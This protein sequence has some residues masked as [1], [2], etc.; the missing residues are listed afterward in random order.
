MTTSVEH[1][2]DVLKRLNPELPNEDE[3]GGF[4]D[5]I[6]TAYEVFKNLVPIREGFS[7]SDKA[8]LTKY[9]NW[10][11]SSL[12]IIRTP[13][14]STVQSVL[15]AVSVGELDRTKA[16]L[17]YDKMF[18]LAL[19]G[20]ITPSSGVNGTP[21]TFLTERNETLRLRLF[22]SNDVGKDTEKMVV[23]IGGKNLTLNNMFDITKRKIGEKLWVY[24]PFKNNCQDFVIQFL[25][26]NGLLTPKISAFVRQNI[27]TIAETLNKHNPYTTDIAKGVIDIASRL[28][29]LTGLGLTHLET[30]KRLNPT[31]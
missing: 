8:F 26:S 14:S 15:N 20:T 21:V 30:A 13:L 4:F 17:G 16:R 27:D 23:P 31:E 3:G 19:I 1:H 18:H 6:K 7:N 28:R 24:D 29:A 25:G 9:G 10:T 12:T 2:I 11:I 5:T 22:Q